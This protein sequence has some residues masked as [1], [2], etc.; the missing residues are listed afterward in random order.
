MVDRSHMTAGNGDR[1]RVLRAS[2][3]ALVLGSAIAIAAVLPAEYGLDPT[4]IGAALGLLPLSEPVAAQQ[5]APVEATA[6]RG[7]ESSRLSTRLTLMPGDGVE[8]KLR[9][10]EDDRVAYRWLASGVL[11]FDLHGEP[12]GG[13]DG[14]Y[15]SY[16]VGNGDGVEGRF[17]AL[18]TGTHGWYWR[19]DSAEA[20]DIDLTVAG[21][22]TGIATP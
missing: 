4:G 13:P 9:V 5:P 8:Y 20:I 2:F 21:R 19:N 7:S 12:A 6:A 16:A 15:E 17:T 14:Y 22:F 10:E 18:F 11:H 3:F 1:R